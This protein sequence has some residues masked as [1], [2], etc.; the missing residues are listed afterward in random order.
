MKRLDLL[1]INVWLALSNPWHVHHAT[2]QNYWA[3][4]DAGMA[5]CQISMQGF[6][7]LVTHPAAMGQAVHTPEEAWDIYN[8]YLRT[9]RVEFLAEP[10]TLEKQ[11]RRYTSRDG[12][13][14]RDW[15]DAWLA[16]FAVTA[17]C[18]IV[19][20]DAGFSQYEGLEFLQLKA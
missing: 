14:V 4:A 19:S 5:F 1:D 3:D 6:L 13:H 8:A 9:S 17:G 11:L 16:S 18:R 10:V 20:F 7:R 15:T 2:A 12:F